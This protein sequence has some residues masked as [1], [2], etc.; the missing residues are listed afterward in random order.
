M[1]KFVTNETTINPI[2]EILGSVMR[3][4]LRNFMNMGLKEMLKP[5]IMLKIDTFIIMLPPYIFVNF[6]HLYIVHI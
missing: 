3:V 5:L 6:V 4:D 1:L 2:T